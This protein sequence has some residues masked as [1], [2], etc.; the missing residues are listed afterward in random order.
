MAYWPLKENSECASAKNEGLHQHGTSSSFLGTCRKTME[1][2]FLSQLFSKDSGRSR[3]CGQ[4]FGV[5]HIRGQ[6]CCHVDP[7][8]LRIFNFHYGRFPKMR[9]PCTPEASIFINTSYCR[10]FHSKPTILGILHGTP[11][12]YMVIDGPIRHG[13]GCEEVQTQLRSSK[14]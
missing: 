3:G 1:E 6:Y 5:E 14:N 8:E 13:T 12:W 2:S 7:R 11:H 10:I 4:E 9:V